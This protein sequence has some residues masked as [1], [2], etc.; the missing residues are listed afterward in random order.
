MKDYSVSHACGLEEI[1]PTLHHAKNLAKTH[2]IKCKNTK[3]IYIDE[4]SNTEG[5][6]TGKYWRV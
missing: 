5:E 1:N 2:K 3:L 4:Y 6:L